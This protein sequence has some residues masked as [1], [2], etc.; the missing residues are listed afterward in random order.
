VLFRK[1]KVEQAIAKLKS[2]AEILP[3]EA[4]IFEHLG[5]IYNHKKDTLKAE[6]YYR[7]AINLNGKK[8]KEAAKKVEQKLAAIKDSRKPTNQ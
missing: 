7:K 1:G 2:A 5:D 6:E 4:V 3:T 8:N